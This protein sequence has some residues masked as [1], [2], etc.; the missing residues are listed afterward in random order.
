MNDVAPLQASALLERIRASAQPL[1]EFPR[2]GRM[3]AGFGRDSLREI[4]VDQY[5]IIYE[6]RRDIVAVATVLHG[7][8]DVEARLHAMRP[9]L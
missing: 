3:V 9:D 4:I 7:A 1:A 2:M 8:Q 5:R 6:L